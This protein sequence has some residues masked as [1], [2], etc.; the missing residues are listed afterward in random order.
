MRI[1]HIT[2]SFQHPMM[3]GPTRHYHFLRE[4]SRQH[5]MTLLALT[6]S[7][8]SPE[9]RQEIASYT[10]RILTFSA[11]GTSRD[12]R[13]K[14]ANGLPLVGNRV[15]Q[16]WQLHN[17]TRQMKRAF[18]ELVRQERYDL[19]LFHGKSVF[20]V[21]EDWN[22]LPIVADFCD[23]T[24]MRIRAKM[25]Y[26]GPGRLPLLVLRY[27]QVR[28][29]EKKLIKK[30]PHLAVISPRDR[31][32]ISSLGNR[33]QILPNGVDLEYWKRRSRDS[34]PNCIIFTGVMNYAPNEDA[35]LVLIEKI[36]PLIRQS[37]PDL[38]VFIVGRDPSPA[39]IEKARRYPDVT[40]TGFVDDMRPYLERAAVCVAPL[41]Y[42]SGMQNKV[43]EAMAMEAPVVTTSIVAEGLRL[44]GADDL[45]V[46]VADR[47]KEFAEQV[48]KLLRQEGARSRLAAE[49]RRFVENNFSWSRSARKLEEMCL[50]A[51]R[52]NG[53]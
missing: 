2:P 4:L 27:L 44:D 29:V 39:L 43:L 17:A 5:T 21:I 51:V 16:A 1:L 31:E 15:E 8:I 49:G 3:R 25:R 28:Q 22:D 10:D 50:D 26:A 45:P 23:A 52:T 9:A 30:T 42:A 14:V 35:A 36:L 20:S 41:R 6:R 13:D 47:E 12:L 19:V 37:I 11:N 24:S 34:Q 40:V 32:A 18:I 46:W 48:V 7:K 53:R 38:D 33:S